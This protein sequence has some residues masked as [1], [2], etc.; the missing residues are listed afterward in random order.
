MKTQLRKRIQYSSDKPSRT[1]QHFEEETNVNSVIKKYQRTGMITH[2]RQG[3]PMYGDF[4]QYGDFKTQ[5][6]SVRSAFDLFSSLPAHVRKKFSN[7]PENLIQ[8]LADSNN[9]EEAIKLGLKERPKKEIP[10]HDSSPKVPKNDDKTTNQG[11][12]KAES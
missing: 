3:Q 2:V 11:T 4:T 1:Q 7:N 6:D 9:D 12:N 5:L 8:F 10:N